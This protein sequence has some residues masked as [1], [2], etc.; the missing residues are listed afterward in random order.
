MHGAGCPEATKRLRGG[1]S[2]QGSGRTCVAEAA[3]ANHSSSGWHAPSPARAALPGRGS[4]GAGGAGRTRR[5]RPRGRSTEA[6][7]NTPRL[8]GA[9]PDARQPIRA[10]PVHGRPMGAAGSRV[11]KAWPRRDRAGR[12]AARV[13][14]RA[15]GRGLRPWKVGERSRRRCGRRGWR[16][17][18]SCGQG[19]P[20]ARPGWLG[21][22][23]ALKGAAA[24]SLPRCGSPWTEFVQ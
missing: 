7:Q 13:L 15:K 12:D 19:S 21:R 1:S 11:I 5:A 8:A 22:E 9:G 4:R 20:W 3:S 17:R 24:C 14:V 18:R 23:T 6:N 2:K 16:G 10:R